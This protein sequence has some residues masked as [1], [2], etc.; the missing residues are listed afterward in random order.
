LNSIADPNWAR[1]AVERVDETSSVEQLTTLG[2][3]IEGVALFE[4]FSDAP[5]IDKAC[6]VGIS[7]MRNMF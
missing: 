1:H 4:Q 5:S 6:L 3:E 2:N 7:S